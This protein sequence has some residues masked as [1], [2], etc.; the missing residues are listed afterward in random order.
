[1][2]KEFG[3]KPTSSEIGKVLG[4][5]KEKVDQILADNVNLV[6]VYEKKGQG[7][8]SIEIIDTIEDFQKFKS[9]VEA[10]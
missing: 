8:D 6:S 2:R 1:M 4:I 7:E 10:K 3:R 5:E 9:M